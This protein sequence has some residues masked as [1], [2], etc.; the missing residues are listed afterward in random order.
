MRLGKKKMMSYLLSVCLLT[1]LCGCGGIGAE[2]V[3]QADPQPVLA[4]AE[5]ISYQLLSQA[6]PAGYL[7]HHGCSHGAVPVYGLAGRK[8]VQ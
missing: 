1:G 2:T 8:A 4:A 3:P 7:P 5:E 6:Q